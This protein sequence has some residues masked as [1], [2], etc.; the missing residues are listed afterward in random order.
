MGRLIAW[1]E[2]WVWGRQ[3]LPRGAAHLREAAR[4]LWL[5]GRDLAEGRLTLQA[6]GLVYTTLLSLVPLLAVSFSVLKAFGVHN[7]IEPTLLNLLA[8]LGPKGAEI[9]A[10]IV[11]FVENVRVGVLG[12]V[13]LGLL[14][15]TVV[16]L[17][18]KIER[19]FNETWRVR[20]ARPL[21]RRFADYLSV[22][23]VGPVLAFSALG[24]TATIRA[25]DWLAGVQALPGVAGLLDEAARLLPYLLIMAAFAFVYVFVPN[26][27]VRL[28]SALVGAAVAGFLWESAGWAFAGFVVGSTKYT[29]I[30]S[31]FA[32]LVLFMIWLYVAWLILLVGASIAFY[33]QHPEYRHPTVERAPLGPAARERLALAV[34]VAVARAWY[35]GRRTRPEEL[36]PALGLPAALVERTV[37]ALAAAGLVGRAEDGALLPAR[38]PE[39]TSVAEVWAAV[40]HPAGGPPVPLPPPAAQLLDEAEAAARRRLETQTLKTLALEGPRPA[41]AGLGPVATV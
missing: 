40:R 36:A 13:G 31:A 6:M 11:G 5:V 25:S 17:V 15:Y 8:P 24:L 3:P 29:A 9:A 33:H 12:S 1:L 2:R 35:G 37:E 38:P 23:L 26:T 34:A 28:R 30:Y 7:Q 41:A 14:L 10:R 32:T 18:N 39:E 21:G 16:S 27:R 22:I 4:I 20:R 19:A